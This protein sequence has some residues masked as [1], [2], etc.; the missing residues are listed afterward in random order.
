MTKLADEPGP[1][2]IDS[3]QRRKKPS[4]TAAFIGAAALATGVLL[5]GINAAPAPAAQKTGATTAAANRNFRVPAPAIDPSSEWTIRLSGEVAEENT[6]QAIDKIRELNKKDPNREITLLI[7]SPGGSVTH[8][9]ALYDVMQSVKN[10]VRT[11]CEGHAASMAAVLLAAG[12]PGK[13]MAYEHCEIMIHEISGET[14]G[15]NNAMRTDMED[16]D[17]SNE[18]IIAILNARTGLEKRV[19]R[20]LM[21]QDINVKDTD[22]AARLGLIDSVIARKNTPPAPPRKLPDDFCKESDRQLLQACPAPAVGLP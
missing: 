13:R 4:V 11:V 15:K 16:Y 1:S 12:T 21:T 20:S 17:R 10:D 22:E 3:S 19:L 5:T 14:K 2:G 6:R 7:N 18:K 8:G 9:L